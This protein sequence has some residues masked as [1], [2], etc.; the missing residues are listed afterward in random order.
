MK[1]I[2]LNTW[3][4]IVYDPLLAFIK[5]QK[6]EI[7][8]FCFQEVLFGNDPV[9]TAVHQGRVN[10]FSELQKCLPDFNAYIYLSPSDYFQDEF[11]TFPEGQVIFVKKGLIVKEEGGF[12]CYKLLPANSD[13]GGK[14]TGNLKWLTIGDDDQ[15]ITIANLHGIWQE[16]VGKFDTSERITQSKIIKDFFSKKTGKKIL[17][18]D[19]N[20]N[21]TTKS[22]SLLEEEMRN[23]VAEYKITCTRSEFYKKEEKFADYI[24]VSPNIEVQDFKV[25]QDSVS[26]HLPLYLQ[27]K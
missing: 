14:V 6:E 26:D 16:G 23:L 22:I 9:V 3:G 5:K 13:L 20:L 8:I 27:F 15:E 4:G 1:L 18:G 10:L 24:F 25:L 11:I 7:D 12:H 19:F 2:T 21:P 17:C